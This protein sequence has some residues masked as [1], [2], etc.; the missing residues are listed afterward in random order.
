MQRSNFKKN[1]LGFLFYG[2]KEQC[3]NGACLLTDD[4]TNFLVYLFVKM[5]GRETLDLA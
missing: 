2:Q 1:L 4:T 5:N 3:G